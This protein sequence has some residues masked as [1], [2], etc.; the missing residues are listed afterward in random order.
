MSSHPRLLSYTR[1]LLQL[2]PD[3][4]GIA[5][6]HVQKMTPGEAEE[7]K[8]ALASFIVRQHG[9]K[10][11]AYMKRREQYLKRKI[12]SQRS[13]VQS[14]AAHIRE[15][16]ELQRRREAFQV[17]LQRTRVR[18]SKVKLQPPRNRIFLSPPPGAG[19]RSQH[20]RRSMKLSDQIG[21][22]CSSDGSEYGYFQSLKI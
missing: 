17:A 4:R 11:S 10:V 8:H 14:K 15:K 21:P 16:I 22:A 9:W 3:L 1:Q 13:H 20:L 18:L 12:I 5:P 6:R 7:A 19:L 2:D